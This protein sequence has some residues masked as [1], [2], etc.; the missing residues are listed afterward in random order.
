MI[1]IQK[2]SSVL[3]YCKISQTF[4]N[5]KDFSSTNLSWVTMK[6]EIN[7]F[8]PCVNSCQILKGWIIIRS[9]VVSCNIIYFWKF[10]SYLKG[11]CQSNIFAKTKKF[12]KLFLSRGP[13]KKKD[14]KSRNTVPLSK[15][16]ICYNDS[17][18]AEIIKFTNILV[19]ACKKEQVT[20]YYDS[21]IVQHNY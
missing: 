18:S 4:S 20:D 1:S 21:N 13:A 3:W 15:I 14:Q 16:K 17:D 7:Q 9:R 12:V 6:W 5:S 2:C 19:Y 11:Q 8:L 10:K